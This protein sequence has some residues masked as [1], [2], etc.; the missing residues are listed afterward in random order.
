[1]QMICRS[2]KLIFV[3]SQPHEF[4]RDT[5]R[6]IERKSSFGKIDVSGVDEILKWANCCESVF[7]ES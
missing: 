4:F 5:Y 1:M 3:V 6:V 7:A 2:T